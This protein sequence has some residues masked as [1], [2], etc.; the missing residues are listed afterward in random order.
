ML[1]EAIQCDSTLENPGLT[2]KVPRSSRVKNSQH[3]IV[4][5]DD[6]PIFITIMKR[7]AEREGFF[8]V[9]YH[10]LSEVGLIGNL[11]S[12]DA[13]IIDY[14]LGTTTGIDI[15]FNSSLNKHNLPIIIVSYKDRTRECVLT[16]SCVKAVLQ[17]S[18]GYRFILQAA[19][20]YCKN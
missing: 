1:M 2:H 4:L 10:S 11:S 9:G 15:A 20:R 12:F 13:A 8:L 17:K 5:I 14:D 7:W 16:P 18:E 19:S 3:R 6:D